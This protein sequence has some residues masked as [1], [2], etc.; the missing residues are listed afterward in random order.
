MFYNFPTDDDIRENK[1]ERNIKLAEKLH[2]YKI[3]KKR[4]MQELHFS[5]NKIIS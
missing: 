3:S 2:E 4:G 5:L 1:N